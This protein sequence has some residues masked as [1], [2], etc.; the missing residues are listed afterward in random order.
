M[1]DKT[2]SFHHFPDDKADKARRATWLEVFDI[3]EE[4]LKPSSRVCSRPFPGGNLKK[5]P[6]LKLGTVFICLI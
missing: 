1:L 4:D 5:K 6:S 3:R 2:A